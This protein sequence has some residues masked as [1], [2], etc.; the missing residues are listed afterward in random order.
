MDERAERI[1]AAC[2]EDFRGQGAAHRNCAQAVLLF[3]LRLRGED[4]ALVE[5]LRY[6]GGG[7]GRA[8]LT[9]GALTGAALALGLR[10]RGAPRDDAARLSR[11][12]DELREL[13]R[14]FGQTLGATDCRALA[15]CDLSTPAGRED[16]HA[17]GV[18]E[19]RCA[20]AVRFACQRL[21]DLG[22][23]EGAR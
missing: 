16:F 15:G 7:L 9:C 11:G 4:E 22:L 14:A 8:G 17:R 5:A 12:R 20:P 19:A 1:L 3:A 2:L 10:D 23:E 6:L 18:L 13:V 21:W